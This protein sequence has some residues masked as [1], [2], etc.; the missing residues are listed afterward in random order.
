[1]G[2]KGEKLIVAAERERDRPTGGCFFPPSGA[3]A[4][5]L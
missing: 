4:L 5:S 2:Q 3:G 1:M